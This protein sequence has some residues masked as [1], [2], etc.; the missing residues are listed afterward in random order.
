[1]KKLGIDQLPVVSEYGVQGMVTLGNLTAKMLSG[2]LN[3][4]TLVGDC[5]LKGHKT[6]DVDCSL[7]RLALIFDTHHYALI[8]NTQKTFGPK[9]ECSEAT[10]VSAVVTRIDLL[11]YITSQHAAAS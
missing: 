3:K 7:G 8:C 5:L 6:I 11:G 2:K 10:M 4:D 9:G 1:M